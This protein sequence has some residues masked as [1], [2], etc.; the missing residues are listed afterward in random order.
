MET[1]PGGGAPWR[2]GAPAE[3]PAR[4]R[5]LAV[6]LVRG[7]HE[8]DVAVACQH[9]VGGRRPRRRAL[10]GPRPAERL[11]VQ[12]LQPHSAQPH[13]PRREH[14]S[15][16]RIVRGLVAAARDGEPRA[17]GARLARQS[18]PAQRRLPERRRRPAHAAPGAPARHALGGSGLLRLA[19]GCLAPRRRGR[20]AFDRAVGLRRLRLVELPHRRGVDRD[21]GVGRNTGDLVG[22]AL[23]V[24]RTREEAA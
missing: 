21:L 19:V 16:G 11:C 13:A 14:V 6:R 8:D 20:G 18:V 3:A 15:R 24:T 5:P 12:G 7:P 17:A 10:E 4:A 2:S 1:S 9:A 23:P 22:H